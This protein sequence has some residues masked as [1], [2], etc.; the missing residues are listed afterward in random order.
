MARSPNIIYV[1]AA[2]TPSRFGKAD[3]RTD[4]EI[5][6]EIVT[7]LGRTDIDGWQLRKTLQTIHVRY[8]HTMFTS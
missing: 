7:Y 4:D 1:F 5:D 3:T 8:S 6:N 2:S